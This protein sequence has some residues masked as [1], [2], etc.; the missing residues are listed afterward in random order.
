MDTAIATIAALIGDTTRANMLL[1]LMGGL[2][3]PAG[4]L[5]MRANVSSQTASSHTVPG[6]CTARIPAE[7]CNNAAYL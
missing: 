2:A 7:H 5:A 4:K 3:L 1:A 6:F